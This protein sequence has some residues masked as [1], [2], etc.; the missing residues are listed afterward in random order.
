VA[1]GVRVRHDMDAQRGHGP[2]MSTLCMAW[3]HNVDT[4]RDGGA[5]PVSLYRVVTVP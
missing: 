1:D 5:G 4:V 2:M 3:M